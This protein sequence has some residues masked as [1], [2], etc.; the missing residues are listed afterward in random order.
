LIT[1]FKFHWGGTSLSVAK[2]VAHWKTTP[3]PLVW[4]C[5]ST[6]ASLGRKTGLV[7]LRMRLTMTIETRQHKARSIVTHS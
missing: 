4:A 6:N 2:G 7:I 1:R 5:H 3:I